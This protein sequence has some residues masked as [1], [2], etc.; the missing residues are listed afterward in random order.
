MEMR[1]VQVTT[2]DG[3]KA[4]QVV[5]L[6]EPDATGKVLVD[7]H[8]AGVNFPDV[9]QTRGEYQLKP[10]LPFVPGAEVAGVVLRGRGA[11]SGYPSG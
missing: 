10:E 6:P 8:A 5:D 9:L 7:V 3:P 11:A 1:A 2:L 4:V